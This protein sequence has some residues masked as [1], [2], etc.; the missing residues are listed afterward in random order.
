VNRLPPRTLLDE[1]LQASDYTLDEWCERFTKLA[2]TLGEN[3]TLSVRQLQRWAAGKTADARPA[4]RRVAARLWGYPF[5]A[6]VAARGQPGD[7]ISPSP[8][9]PDQHNPRTQ[10][11]GIGPPSP[12][13]ALVPVAAETD[14]CQ[15]LLGS[16][17]AFAVGC[18]PADLSPPLPAGPRPADGVP[19][20]VTVEHVAMLR[21]VV[22]RH[23]RFDADH[24][25][26]SCR[27][28]AVAYLHWAQG[29]LGSRF[30]SDDIER[31]LKAALSDMYQVAGWAC[32]DLG[33]HGA[34]RRYLTDGLRVARAIDDLPLIAGAFYRL[35]RVSIHQG[36]AQEAQR[37]WQLGQLVAQDSGCLV[38]VA[39][40]HANQAWAYAMLG[41]ADLVRDSLARA[42]GEL[43][44]VE[45]NVPSW[46]Q[47]FLAPAD[48]NGISGLV[49]T[50]L[51]TH[52][53]HRAKYAPLAIERSALALEQRQPGET[54]SRTF[55]AISLASSHLLDGDVSTAERYAHMAIDMTDAIDS[56]RACDRL[57]AV[58]HLA[59]PY[60]NN[61]GVAGVLERIAR[62][63]PS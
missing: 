41:S 12:S 19:S 34:A 21:E 58:A 54:R 38:S 10:V 57:H 53:H 15:D 3:A 13:G 61:S 63:S 7:S 59:Q 52:P 9:T 51:A 28:S 8:G 36:R 39:V 45:T 42:E 16:L 35:G 47:F 37:L 33:D 24:G 56:E 46:A 23:R 49:Y 29:L 22:D 30:A 50:C 14:H 20:N 32:H 62:T 40:L 4:S 2:Q 17:A 44:R 18:M 43:A 55:D 48:I 6:L 1:L 26:G 27:D 5:A 11:P 31:A 60:A 25:G